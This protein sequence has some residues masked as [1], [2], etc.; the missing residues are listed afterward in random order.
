MEVGKLLDNPALA[1]P[2]VETPLQLVGESAGDK[3]I[4]NDQASPGPQ[5]AVGLLEQQTLIRTVSVTTA[6]Q[7]IDS[8]IAGAWQSCMLVVGFDHADTV[9]VTGCLV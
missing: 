3:C 5:Q 9:T 8:V 7:R 2:V 4:G 6:L 1:Y